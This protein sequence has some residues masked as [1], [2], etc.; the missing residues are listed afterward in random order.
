MFASATKFILHGLIYQ[1]VGI[2]Y[3]LF[4][5]NLGLKELLHRFSISLKAWMKLLLQVD[6]I[7]GQSE[8]ISMSDILKYRQRFYENYHDIRI[9]CGDR[10]SLESIANRT[11]EA[12]SSYNR[13]TNFTSTRGA[14]SCGFFNAILQGLAKDGGLF[15]PENSL[16]KFRND[17]LM[18]LVPLK[19]HERAL[20]ILEKLIHPRHIHRSL[21]REYVGTAYSEQTFGAGA[22][23]VVAVPDEPRSLFVSELF[24]G[25]TGSFKDLALQLMPYIFS[26]AA[27][28]I[29]KS[30]YDFQ[31]M[32]F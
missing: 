13:S 29:D 8:G 2:L 1:T 21:L 5:L 24:H 14:D 18:R 12:L 22:C 28:R 19:Y 16:P 27:E 15:V 31:R 32:E 25:P 11:I 10:E 7:V 17:E 26:H 30:R 20:R 23:R 9:I 3:N 4:S 6:R